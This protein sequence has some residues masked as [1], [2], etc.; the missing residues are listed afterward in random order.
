VVHVEP[1]EDSDAARWQGSGRLLHRQ[2][3]E[4]IRA[5]LTSSDDDPAWTAR[6]GEHI[7]QIRAEHAD[8]P[9]AGLRLVR[10]AAGYRLWTFAGGAA[11]NLLARCVEAIPGRRCTVH[12]LYIGF[13]EDAARSE[14]AIHQAI[15]DLRGA[16]RPDSDEALRLASS[17]ATGRL[18]KFEPCLLDHLLARLHASFLTDPAAARAALVTMAPL[19]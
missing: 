3:C 1:I 16:G 18:S 4:A 9:S 6:A 19:P 12:N 8:T 11:N 15:V 13:R 7:Q 2:L 5:I 14:I 17:C 10:D